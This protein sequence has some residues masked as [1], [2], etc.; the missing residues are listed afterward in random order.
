MVMKIAAVM[1]KKRKCLGL[2]LAVM[3]K[4]LSRSRLGPALGSPADAHSF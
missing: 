4:K 3:S 2:L 1:K